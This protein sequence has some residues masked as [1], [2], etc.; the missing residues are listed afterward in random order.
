[1]RYDA[2][3]EALREFLIDDSINF[4]SAAVG[5][6]VNMIEYNDITAI[7]GV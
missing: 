6:D 1:V 5:N 3:S 2:V 7:S 4:C